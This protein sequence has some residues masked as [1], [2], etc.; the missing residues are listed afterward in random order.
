MSKIRIGQYVQGLMGGTI[1]TEKEKS[2]DALYLGRADNGSG[3]SVFRLDTKVVVSVNRT[4]ILPTPGTVIDR[5]NE[6]GVSVK[7]PEGIRFS[8]K[9]SRVT[10]NDL[11]LKMDNDDNNRNASGESFDHDKEYQKNMR[12]KIKMKNLQPTKTQVDNF[13]LPFQQYHALLTDQSKQGV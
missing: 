10:I 13:Q 5:V 3:H 7:Q 8:D 2:I 9:D 12:K 11:N 4:V 1:D 6:M